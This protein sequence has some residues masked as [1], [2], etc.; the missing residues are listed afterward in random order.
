MKFI[1]IGPMKMR[2]HQAC[3]DAQFVVQQWHQ[4]L[5]IYIRDCDEIIRNISI[6]II[7][8]T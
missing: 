3:A 1:D 8:I 6:I 5:N 4:P 7:I 2:A